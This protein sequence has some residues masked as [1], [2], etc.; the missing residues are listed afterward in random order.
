MELTLNLDAFIT[1]GPTVA[2]GE[3][4]QVICFLSS[5][6]SSSSSPSSDFTKILYLTLFLFNPCR[7]EKIMKFMRSFNC[8]LKFVIGSTKSEVGFKCNLV[9]EKRKVKKKG[10]CKDS[11]V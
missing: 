6:K 3:F 9:D 1:S 11:Q 5:S 10:G 7:S 8:V 2:I 4:E